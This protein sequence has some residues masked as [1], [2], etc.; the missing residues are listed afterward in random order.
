M[1]EELFPTILKVVGLLGIF[2]GG[3]YF[4]VQDPTGV[5]L[6]WTIITMFGGGALCLA[7]AYFFPS[8]PKRRR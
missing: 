8:P 5:P 6:L 3:L 1:V 4:L 7:Q 2:C